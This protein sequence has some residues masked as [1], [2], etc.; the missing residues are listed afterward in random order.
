MTSSSGSAF[1]KE[2][3]SARW[4]AISP[5]SEGAWAEDMSEAWFPWEGVT[6]DQARKLYFELADMDGCLRWTDVRVLVGWVRFDPE[7]HDFDGS[8][9][10]LWFDCSRSDEMAV[11]VWH[12]IYIERPRAS[13]RSLP[14]AQTKP[15]TR[16]PTHRTGGTE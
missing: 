6:R 8:P 4:Q 11:P 15:G 13:R 5:P 1:G 10:G 2:R 3:R 12:V 7:A 14:S 9:T 16:L